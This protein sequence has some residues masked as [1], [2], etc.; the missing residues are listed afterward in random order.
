[1]AA[2]KSK[3]NSDSDHRQITFLIV[4][5]SEVVTIDKPVTNN[6]RKSDNHIVINDEHVSRYH[7]QIKRIK[8]RYVILDLNST[9]GTSV[10]GKRIDRKTLKPGDV[11]SLGGVPLIYGE[12]APM[13]GFESQNEQQ[14]DGVD[15]GP[16]ENTDIE[17]VDKY[18]D[19]FNSQEEE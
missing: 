16:T 6:G 14:S 18:L 2:E 13:T 5:G 9:V 15:S 17:S 10:N 19:L 7:A 8:G 3:I 11:I 12:G 4:D 1:M